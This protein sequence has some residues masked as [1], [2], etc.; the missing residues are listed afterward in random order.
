[1]VQSEVRSIPRVFRRADEKRADE[2]EWV[3]KEVSEEEKRDRRVF[4]KSVE[5]GCEKLRKSFG[6]RELMVCPK[7]GQV[8]VRVG[9]ARGED[10]K[11]WIGFI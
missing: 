2:G 8:D 11:F 5:K 4:H 10:Q 9:R 7:N 6:F 3:K 1:M